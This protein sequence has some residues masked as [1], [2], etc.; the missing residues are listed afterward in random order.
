MPKMD[1]GKNAKNEKLNLL[2]TVENGFGEL[3]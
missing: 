3:G 2:Q 1:L